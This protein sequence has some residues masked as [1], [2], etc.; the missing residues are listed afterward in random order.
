[1]HKGRTFCAG[2]GLLALACGGRDDRTEIAPSLLEPVALE[3]QLAFVDRAGGRAL[4]VDVAAASPDPVVA[5]LPPGA[6]RALRRPTQDELLVLCQGTP[7]SGGDAPAAL[8]VIGASGETTSYVLGSRFDNLAVSED[9]RYAVA[10]FSEEAGPQQDFLFNPNEIAIIDLGAP[11]AARN[12]SA[13]TLESAGQ[14]L[15]QVVFSPEMMIAGEARRLAVARFDSMLA[16]M[17][18]G[19][20]DRPAVTVSPNINPLFEEA[21]F[22]PEQAKIYVRGRASNDVYVL[23]FLESDGT[24][25]NDFTVS[26]NQL[27]AGRPPAD[28]A[29]IGAADSERLLVAAGN[30]LVIDADSNRV[31]ELPLGASADSVLLFE[32]EAPLDP[33]VEQ[34]ALLYAR[35]GSEL[36]FLDLD[37]VEERTTRNLERISLNQTFRELVRIDEHL[38]LLL[39]SGSGLGLLD[40]EERTVAPISASITLDGAVADPALDRLWVAPPN[41]PRLGFLD[42]NTFHPSDLRL[43]APIQ[44]LFSFSHLDAPRIAITHPSSLGHVT[45]LDARDPR[46]FSRAVSLYGFVYSG[47]FDQGEE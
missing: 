25:I 13:R 39:Y 36:T 40:L 37:R 38:V 18:L 6:V 17:D 1:M 30:A 33:E 45:L 29:V 14:T 47:T 3:H 15:R 43:N 34:R 4:L 20:L 2:L 5:E 19:H 23:Q 26:L 9:G 22:A 27:G 16:I 8:A 31:T 28:M 21:L 11:P 7:D 24:R 32:G 41:Q 46:A 44:K 42:L 12:P 10:Y 35:Q